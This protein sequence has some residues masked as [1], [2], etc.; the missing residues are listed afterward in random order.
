M[1]SGKLNWAGSLSSVELNW[2]QFSTEPVF[3]QLTETE[4]E[5]EKY[6]KNNSKL[7]VTVIVTEKSEIT[8]TVSV[9][10]KCNKVN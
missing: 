8:V 1:H 4:T 3:I 7:T 9:T 10:E 6:L 5:I 2:D